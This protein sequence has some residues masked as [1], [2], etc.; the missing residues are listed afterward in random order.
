MLHEIPTTFPVTIRWIPAHIGIAGNE[1]ADK[2]AKEATK[3]K[4]E[5]LQAVAE[6]LER[7]LPGLFRLASAAKTVVRREAHLRWEQQWESTKTSAPTKRLIA[8]PTKHSLRVYA[9]LRKAHSS[10]LMQLRTGRIGLNHFLYKIGLRG[11]D[12]CGCDEGSQTPK[13]ILLECRLLSDLQDEMWRRINQIGLKRREDF[14][15]LANEPNAAQFVADFMIKAGQLG[16]FQ[17]VVPLQE[18]PD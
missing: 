18:E 16:Q 12:R 3:D 17:A 9:G 10:V 6:A 7:P 8:A 2:A 1:A 14:N 4:G 13:H 11:S 15:T 5:A